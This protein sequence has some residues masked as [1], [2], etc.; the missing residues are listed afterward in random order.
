ML[1]GRNEEFLAL[2]LEVDWDDPSPIKPVERM[3]AAAYDVGNGP[4]DAFLRDVARWAWR[5]KLSLHLSIDLMTALTERAEEEAIRVFARNLKDLLLA[6][7]PARA[8][9]WASTP[10][11]APG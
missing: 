3:I 4:G 10:A 1:R 8:T 11:S 2:D 6:A 5:V 9:P 7:P